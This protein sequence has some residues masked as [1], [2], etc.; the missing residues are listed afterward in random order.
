MY[1]TLIHVV[2]LVAIVLTFSYGEE[3]NRED[4]S[5]RLTKSVEVSETQRVSEHVLRV[6]QMLKSRILNIFNQSFN[7]LLTSKFRW[8]QQ[9]PSSGPE[10]YKT[11]LQ[12]SLSKSKS[13]KTMLP[14]PLSASPRSKRSLILPGTNYCGVGND[15]TDITSVGDMSGPNRC[16]KEHDTCPYTIQ[17]FQTK[18]N[19]YN[20][21]FYT[22]SHCECD[23]IFRT[24]LRM[25]G[26]DQADVVGRLYFNGIGMK[27]FIFRS[28]PVCLERE[29]WG[30]CK[31]QGTQTAAQLRNPLQY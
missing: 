14:M 22:L 8:K 31:R 29:W 24:C 9:S 2:I 20:F 16:C 19:L 10:S 11:F 26:T 4:G 28:E 5:L 15:T 6:P 30:R 18:Y 12:R 13:S 3:E 21:R 17:G 1:K 7:D 25:S 27:C 23:D